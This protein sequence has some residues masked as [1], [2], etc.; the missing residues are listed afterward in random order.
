MLAQ[1][2]DMARWLDLALAA[3][4]PLSTQL[5]SAAG[6]GRPETE[7]AREAKGPVTP[8]GGAFV[9]WAPIFVC[10]LA[11]GA[12]RSRV[13]DPPLDPGTLAL[14][15]VSLLGNVAWNLSAQLHGFGWSTVGLIGASAATATAAVARLERSRHATREARLSANLVA[16]LAGWLTVAT[17]ANVETTQRQTGTTA[18]LA[19][20][21][22][23]PI[24]AAAAGCGV[25]ATRA[26]PLYTSAAAW[27]LAGIAVRNA[28]RRPRLASAA[29]VGLLGVLALAAVVHGAS[30]RARPA[31]E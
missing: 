4:V 22:L 15:R 31:L 29:T 2:R 27:G 11:F 13:D 21:T 14:V 1:C 6:V 20:G 17:F 28:G 18:R 23:I 16:P 24:A 26:N 7:R 30:Q 3:M 19:A 25:V 12:R 5:A 9:I 8:V 10:L